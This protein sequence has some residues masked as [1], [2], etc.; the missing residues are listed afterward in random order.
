MRRLGTL[1]TDWPDFARSLGPMAL[2]ALAAPVVPLR[3]PVLRPIA[4]H[5]G[6]DIPI[7][8]AFACAT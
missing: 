1:P 5:V 3:I 6:L 7:Y 2:L 8:Y 4:V